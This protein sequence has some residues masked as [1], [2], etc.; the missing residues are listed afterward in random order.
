MVNLLNRVSSLRNTTE[1]SDN[2]TLRISAFTYYTEYRF[3]YTFNIV[4]NLDF[5]DNRSYEKIGD[6]SINVSR[7]QAIT[8]AEN[9]AKNY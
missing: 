1:T 6:T 9:Y 5:D 2:I 8:I 3:N 7:E 4:A